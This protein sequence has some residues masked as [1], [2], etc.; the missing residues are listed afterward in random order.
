MCKQV[1]FSNWLPVQVSFQSKTE[2]KGAKKVSKCYT[3]PAVSKKTYEILKEEIRECRM[4]NLPFNLLSAQE[5]N[6]LVKKARKA[7]IVPIFTLTHL[8]MSVVF[9]AK[10]M[11]NT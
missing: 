8:T 4:Q 2:T 10:S 5:Q 11:Q 1:Y 9:S 3:T 6:V 7:D